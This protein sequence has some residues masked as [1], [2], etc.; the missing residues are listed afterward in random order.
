MDAAV[1]HQRHLVV[2]ARRMTRADCWLG[3][4][5][6]DFI[7]DP[8]MQVLGDMLERI[9]QTSAQQSQTSSTDRHA[10]G[11]GASSAGHD[12]APPTILPGTIIIIIIINILTLPK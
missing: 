6:I 9:I 4:G 8:S 3:A 10:G 7:V 12:P 5:F 1:G 11:D 2:N